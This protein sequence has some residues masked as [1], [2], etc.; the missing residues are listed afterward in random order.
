MPPLYLRPDQAAEVLSISR[1]YL[2]VLLKNNVIPSTKCGRAR[3]IAVA[4]LHALR[5]RLANS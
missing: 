4:D 2:Y 5:S 1:P 3:L